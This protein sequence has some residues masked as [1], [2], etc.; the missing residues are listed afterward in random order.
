MELL[1]VQE[2]H[3]PTIVLYLTSCDEMKTQSL[4]HLAET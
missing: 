3:E 1:G 4:V 2:A